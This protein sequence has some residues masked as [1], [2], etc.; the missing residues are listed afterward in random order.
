VTTWISQANKEPDKIPVLT[1][2]HWDEL[3]SSSLR[4]VLVDFWSEGCPPCN[5]MRTVI[6]ELMDEC[7]DVAAFGAVDV[8]ANPEIAHQYSVSSVPT[9][10]IF[11][12]GQPVR[13]LVGARPKRHVLR[14]LSAYFPPERP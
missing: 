2:D 3:V 10:V 4:P 9:L 12:N 13:R 14:E 8:V 7:E 5:Q 11:V 6:H 1:S